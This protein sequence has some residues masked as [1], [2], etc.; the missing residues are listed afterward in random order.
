MARIFRQASMDW[1]LRIAGTWSSPERPDITYLPV[2]QEATDDVDDDEDILL[3]SADHKSTDAV[4]SFDDDSPTDGVAKRT[5]RAGHSFVEV[6]MM[7]FAVLAM[8]ILAGG[9]AE[10]QAAQMQPKEAMESDDALLGLSSKLRGGPRNSTNSSSAQANQ[11]TP[12]V[13]KVISKAKAWFKKQMPWLPVS[14]PKVAT[15]P[16]NSPF[17]GYCRFG[18]SGR[19]W[20]SHNSAYNVDACKQLCQN[21]T[22]CTAYAWQTG[23]TPAPCDLYAGGPYTHGDGHANTKCYTL[24]PVQMVTVLKHYAHK[25]ESQVLVDRTD[26]FQ[27]GQKVTID[28]GAK[29]ETNWIV[30][31]GSLKLKNPLKMDHNQGVVVSTVMPSPKKSAKKAAKTTTTRKTSTVTKVM[32]RKVTTTTKSSTTSAAPKKSGNAVQ[33][34]DINGVVDYIFDH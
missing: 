24:K 7:S 14:S 9:A 19:N 26:G 20:I 6:F 17:T 34:T 8:L 10:Q 11:S 2:Q 16:L 3:Y 29:Q 30:G 27:V 33:R 32:D 13:K 18:S 4:N 28:T 12:T 15:Q 21:L 1:S 25:G 31:F 5:R 23:D 22:M